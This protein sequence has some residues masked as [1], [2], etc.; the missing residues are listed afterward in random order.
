MLFA[1]DG[2]KIR[3]HE[4]T[5]R[6]TS[7]FGRQWL[8][9]CLFILLRI[10]RQSLKEQLLI[11]AGHVSFTAR[12]KHRLLEY[13][14]LLVSPIE[15]ELQRLNLLLLESDERRLFSDQRIL[16]GGGR[17][18]FLGA[19]IQSVEPLQEFVGGTSLTHAQI[20]MSNC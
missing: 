12:P 17:C 5:Q 6:F 8:R 14:Q 4:L 19:A 1:T 10:Q 16:L 13:R 20:Y 2:Q 9:H 15:G 11:G 7:G 18:Q 3:E